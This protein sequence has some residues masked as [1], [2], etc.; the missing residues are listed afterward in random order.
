VL[1]ELPERYIARA[2]EW[3]P[4]TAVAQTLGRTTPLT[5]AALL[6]SGREHLTAVYLVAGQSIASATYYS[7]STPLA[8]GNNQW[9]SLRSSARGL[10]KITSD[11]TSTAWSAN[12][13]KTLTFSGGAYLVPSTGLYYLGVMVN[14]GTAPSLVASS[15]GSGAFL[16]YAVAPVSNGHD[17]TNL[18]LTTPATAPATSAALTGNNS[19][20]YAIVS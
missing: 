1:A 5:N 6:V 4:T 16:V 8:G 15:G 13:A 9:F 18:G 10:L 17:G 14:A 20:P 3:P 11:D 7:A 12:T 19:I 2:A